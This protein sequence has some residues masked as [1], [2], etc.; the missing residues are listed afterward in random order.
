MDVIASPLLTFSAL[1]LII[2]MLGVSLYMLKAR[3]V[4]LENKLIES[5]GINQTKFERLEEIISSSF[6]ES[7]SKSQKRID[8]LLKTLSDRIEIS[9]KDIGNSVQTSQALI[10]DSISKLIQENEQK[11]AESVSAVG[12][13]VAAV[14]EN[15]KNNAIYTRGVVDRSGL[16]ITGEI[17]DSAKALVETINE[18]TKKLAAEG[19]E[20]LGEL[21]AVKAEIVGKIENSSKEQTL[22]ILNKSNDVADGTK[23]LII[24]S[25]DGVIDALEL[26]RVS[27]VLTENRNLYDQGR[28]VLETETFVKIFDSCQLT[29]IEDKE[30]GQ[31]TKNEYQNGKISTSK[32]Y[33]TDSLEYVGHY[34]DG[35]LKKMEDLTGP[36]GSNVTQY[37]YDEAGEVE[38][39]I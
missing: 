9:A 12:E 29:Q 1:S 33:R 32:T 31:V 22:E 26:V 15:V 3:M 14:A 24:G 28:L 23:E 4:L 36:E 39:V 10:E 5:S 19:E 27:N 37:E 8:Q 34:Q 21:K 13:S 18:A 6:D 16:K 38:S 7:E 35:V 20:R 11:M 30:T 2:V 25:A 17:S